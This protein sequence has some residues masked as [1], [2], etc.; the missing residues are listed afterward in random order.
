MI[1]LKYANWDDLNGFE[2]IDEDNIISMSI[3]ASKFIDNDF[4]SYEGKRCKLT[5][6]YDEQIVSIFNQPSDD[7]FFMKN[8]YQYTDQM[9]T[10]ASEKS[11]YIKK[12]FILRQND[13]VLFSGIPD[14]NSYS[15]NYAQNTI[16]FELVD[17]SY[18]LFENFEDNS[19]LRAFLGYIKENNTLSK[20]SQPNP[21]SPN[22]MIKQALA[23]STKYPI[24]ISEMVNMTGLPEDSVFMQIPVFTNIYNVFQKTKSFILS[25]GLDWMRYSCYI[26]NEPYPIVSN[27]TDSFYDNLFD[28]QIKTMLCSKD[29]KF[30]WMKYIK[31]YI[32]I[33]NGQKK[34]YMYMGVIDGVQD[35][36]NTDVS[37]SIMSTNAPFPF[38]AKIDIDIA[39]AESITSD[40]EDYNLLKNILLYYPE[41]SVILSSTTEIRSGCNFWKPQE[42][43][44]GYLSRYI[45]D[46]ISEFYYRIYVE[47]QKIDF[48]GNFYFNYNLSLNSNNEIVMDN[49]H[50]IF[51]PDK[52]SLSEFFKIMCVSTTKFVKFD[53]D[54]NGKLLVQ[55][56]NIPIDEPVS[57]SIDTQKVLTFEKKQ[58]VYQLQKQLDEL[59]FAETDRHY[60]L[61]AIKSYLLSTLQ[62]SAYKVSA[63]L[64]LDSQTNNIAI[65]DVVQITLEPEDIYMVNSVEKDKINYTVTL[66]LIKL[67]RVAKKVLDISRDK[68]VYWQQYSYGD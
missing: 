29:S 35:I 68:L 47:N 34:R 30:M 28:D 26:E 54:N 60:V 43:Q 23:F 13:E 18:I 36:P 12:L 6:L 27:E 49:T 19:D 14:Y 63:Q 61:Y 52:F 38:W 57:V 44:S 39:E 56:D 4:Y 51:N 37:V 45:G 22:K 67:K 21:L 59:N 11:K 53:F 65:G 31:T 17:M 46:G 7:A 48:K 10:I 25:K 64:L 9:E 42:V 40:D 32:L 58:E 41:D 1:T 66:E 15:R 2:T 50:G 3:D 24:D 5:V 8:F 33:N 55:L 62:P 16:D 20:D